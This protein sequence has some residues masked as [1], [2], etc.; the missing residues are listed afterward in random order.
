MVCYSCF[1]GVDKPKLGDGDGHLDSV[2]IVNCKV[3]KLATG[4]ATVWPVSQI[5]RQVCKQI[6]LRLLLGSFVFDFLLY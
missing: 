5:S 2:L 6:H 4:H 3:G 1:G